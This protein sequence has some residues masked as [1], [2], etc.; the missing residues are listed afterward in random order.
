MF[1]NQLSQANSHLVDQQEMLPHVHDTFDS[2]PVYRIHFNM[3][4]SLKLYTKDVI[5]KVNNVWCNTCFIYGN[6]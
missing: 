2:P 4:I 3:K 6:Y 1:I 5:Q